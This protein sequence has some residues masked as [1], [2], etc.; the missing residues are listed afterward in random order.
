M[1]GLGA[2]T[3]A[4]PPPPGG[5]APRSSAGEGVGDD[6]ANIAGDMTAGL[7]GTTVALPG[8]QFQ[9]MFATSPST[10]I[11]VESDQVGTVKRAEVTVDGD[12]A[13]QVVVDFYGT[14]R[15][16]SVDAVLRYA[17]Y[18]IG[19]SSEGKTPAATDTDAHARHD[20]IRDEA[21]RRARRLAPLKHAE[22][23]GSMRQASTWIEGEAVVF[24]QYEGEDPVT[25]M[26]ISRDVCDVFEQSGQIVT[27]DQLGT[28]QVETVN[29]CQIACMNLVNVEAHLASSADATLTGVVDKYCS[30]DAPGTFEFANILAYYNARRQAKT[31]RADHAASFPGGAIGLSSALSINALEALAFDACGKCPAGLGR[32][33]LLAMVPA[34]DRG[35]L[36]H[37]LKAGDLTE[38]GQ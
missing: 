30:A 5:E 37:L 34:D 23:V 11:D 8:F 6:L 14:E 31:L 22:Y 18:A 2:K 29:C 12:R 35:N 1:G 21:V 32:A 10:A 25:Q 24:D 19:T 20:V 28:K 16:M 9:H 36:L 4:P 3:S 26:Q 38:L 15:C 33:D 17:V 13:I 7:Q 27:N